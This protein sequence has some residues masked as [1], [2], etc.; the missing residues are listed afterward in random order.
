[1]DHSAE[2]V[3][4]AEETTYEQVNA[5][6]RQISWP[7][8]TELVAACNAMPDSAEMDSGE[9]RDL[10]ARFWNEYLYPQYQEAYFR[11]FPADREK[12][13]DQRSRRDMSVRDYN[14]K[15]VLALC[16]WLDEKGCFHY[17]DGQ[18]AFLEHDAYRL[19]MGDLLVTGAPMLL[20]KQERVALLL[21]G[22]LR[23][24]LEHRR[25]S[26][27]AAQWAVG[28]AVASGVLAVILVATL[29]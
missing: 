9:L 25:R 12:V 19:S 3:R 16:D 2:A 1:M 26:A 27:A 21:N 15:M 20:Y 4:A 13:A 24:C 8:Q 10:A 18:I 14:R 29:I 17:F 23:R 5:R 11:R 28:L 7:D 22:L 6:C